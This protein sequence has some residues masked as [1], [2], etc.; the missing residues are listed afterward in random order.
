M[1][2]RVAKKILKNEQ[3]LDYQKPQVKKAKVVAQ[4]AVRRAEDAAKA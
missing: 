4:R 2:L 1:K 3:V